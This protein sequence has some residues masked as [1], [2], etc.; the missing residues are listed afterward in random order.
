[1]PLHGRIEIRLPILL[2]TQWVARFDSFGC[3]W[4][5][6][7]CLLDVLSSGIALTS[8]P[9][10]TFPHVPEPQPLSSSIH[11]K[12]TISQATC[13]SALARIEPTDNLTTE[14]D[15]LAL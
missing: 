13:R 6:G 15:I 4:W 10:S 14:S 2:V 12:P 8:A 11:R 7:G 3:F 5:D 9:P 1:M